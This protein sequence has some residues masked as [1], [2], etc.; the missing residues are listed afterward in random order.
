M[1]PL[2][3]IMYHPVNRAFF[4]LLD[5][6]PVKKGSAAS[7]ATDYARYSLVFPIFKEKR[8]KADEILF[9]EKI[10]GEGSKPLFAMYANNIY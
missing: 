1:F 2:T 5:I 10:D 3:L 6:E 4:F 8:F 7:R 9:W